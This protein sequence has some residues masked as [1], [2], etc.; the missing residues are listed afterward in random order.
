MCNI[1]SLNLEF[2]T[3]NNFVMQAV[4]LQLG[5]A[6]GNVKAS[7]AVKRRLACEQVEVWDEV[8]AKISHSD[9]IS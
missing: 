3:Y 8:G 2:G 7:L 4:E 6:I 5:F 1:W 9:A